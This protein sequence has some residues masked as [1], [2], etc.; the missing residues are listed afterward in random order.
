[1]N[2]GEYRFSPLA[3]IQLDASWDY[4]FRRFGKQQADRYLDGLFSAVEEVAANGRYLGLA[5][6]RVPPDLIGEITTRP[7]LYIRYGKHYLYLRDLL[8]GGIG[9]VCILGDRMDTP[10]RLKENL[11][12]PTSKIDDA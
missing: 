5:P 4:S 1:M 2:R 12:S 7:I 6:K 8:N 9:V 10:R 3:E 11:F